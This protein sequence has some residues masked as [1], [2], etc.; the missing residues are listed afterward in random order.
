MSWRTCHACGEGLG[1]ML[2]VRAV[3]DGA[4]CRGDGERRQGHSEADNHGQRPRAASH[5]SAMPQRRPRWPKRM[6][7]GP[8]LRPWPLRAGAGG[9]AGASAEEPKRRR[10]A[11]TAAA[12]CARTPPSAQNTRGT[13]QPHTRAG[14]S[15][16]RGGS[17]AAS[18]GGRGGRQCAAGWSGGTARR[19]PD[20]PCCCL[21]SF[22]RHTRRAPASPSTRPCALP[23]AVFM[24]V[25]ALWAF[26][27]ALEKVRRPRAC[28]HSGVIH[29]S[30]A[31]RRVVDL[32]LGRCALLCCSA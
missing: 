9:G 16:Q 24:N 5:H 28:V 2:P 19:V 21:F 1:P 8:G 7:D 14:R 18:G 13:H 11:P 6:P 26:I 29:D 12:A 23:H 30:T 31:V 3:C 15:V 20:A 27:R 17:D 25:S 10:S 32:C 22:P 4:S